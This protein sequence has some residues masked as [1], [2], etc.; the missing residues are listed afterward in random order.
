MRSCLTT[1]HVVIVLSLGL[2]VGQTLFAESYPDALFKGMKYRLIGPW[3]GGRALTAVGVPSEPN[4]YYFGA[5]AGGVWKTTN[6]GMSWTPLFDK[7]AVSS[8]GSVAV[9]DSDPSILYV[10]TGEACI[11]GNISHGDGVYKS[12]DAGKTWKNIGL[13][14]TRHI[15]RVLIHPRNPDIA[16][17]AALGHAYGVNAERGVFRTTDGGKTWEKVLYKDEKTGAIDLALDP[18]NPGVLFAVLWEAGRTPWSLTS[19]GPGS[20]LYRSGDGGTTWKKVEGNGWPA[21]TLGKIGVSVSG[22]DSNRVYAIVEALEEA[23]GVYRSDDGGEHWTQTTSDHR[24]R[25]R[26]W[27]YTHVTA[28]S[29]S[30]DTL[31]VLNTSL[32]KSTDG[33]KSWNPVGG[34]PHGDHHGLWVDPKDSK[35]MINA[36][37]GGATISVDGGVTWSRQDNQPTAQFYH[38]ATDN[39]FPYYVYGSQQD[40]SSIGIASR[41]DD[42]N[43]G[44][45]DWDPVGGGEAGYIAPHPTDPNI[46]YAGEYIGILTRYDRRTKQAQNVSVWPDDTDG[47]EA[48]NMKYRFNWT[49]PIHTSKHDPDVVFYAGNIVFKSTNGG[50][51]WTPISPDLTRNDKSK[52]QR[53]GGPITGENISIETYDVVFSFAESPLQND[54]LWAGTDDGLVQLTRDGGKTWTNVTPREMPEWSM[55]SIVDASPHDPGSAFIAVDRHKLDD[56]RPYVYKTHDYGK[57]WTKVVNGIA[58]NTFVRAVREDPKKK[59]LLYAGT[60]TGVYVSFDD[61][62]RWQPL[63]LNLP[64][65]PIHDLTV[66]D[67][68]LVVATHGRAFWILDDLAPLRQASA[69]VAPADAHLFAPSTA[70]RLRTA[71]S[72][73]AFLGENPPNGAVIYYWLKAEPKEETTLEI[74]DD[75]GKLVRRYTSRPKVV[76]GKPLP[77]RPTT[78]K[79]PEPLPTAAALNR[80]V[81]D[82]RHQMPDL[83]PNAIYDMGAPVAP[84]VLPGR[85]QVRLN[86]AGKSY[87]APLE[88][89]LDP[90][91]TTPAAA[92]EKQLALLAEIRDLIGRSHDAVLGIRGLRAQLDALKKRLPSDDKGKAVAAAAE[93]MD[94]KMAPAEEEL[95]EVKARS[96]Q[97]M[98]NYPTTLNS[99]IAYLGEVVDSADTAPTEQSYQIFQEFKERAERALATWREVADRDVADLNTLMAQNGVPAVGVATG[100]SPAGSR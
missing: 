93:S 48:A 70:L 4:T 1:F 60:E 86:V 75:K 56:F 92:L 12:V 90:R 83:V 22:G 88:V 58:P 36:N 15:G 98:C 72:R 8:I 44:R 69:D 18:K 52:Q 74:L 29:Q 91:V 67:N 23:G 57:T 45:E 6:G 87:T 7:E 43:I 9:S 35:R 100:G 96:S 2:A 30:V 66:K 71:R 78:E 65:T 73:G 77:E 34:I 3:R 27:Y 32:Y 82:L 21:G 17:V 13:K 89:K 5:V 84:L 95:I 85:Y 42:G 33:G 19:G 11:R 50:M 79:D 14:D 62:A 26:P 53:S 68:D 40:N 41:G 39:Q 61:G 47:H 76:E 97:D 54:L 38:V 16:Y 10:G 20:G 28:D 80:W 46:V 24:L 49:E 55:V 37:D 59:G 94:K 64:T 51:S 31:Y 25:H 99:K 81:W 63:Q